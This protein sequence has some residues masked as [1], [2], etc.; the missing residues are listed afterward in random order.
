MAVSSNIRDWGEGKKKAL[1][2]YHAKK[3]KEGS[4]EIIGTD[5]TEGRYNAYLRFS[6]DGKEISFTN[7]SSHGI[8]E[9]LKKKRIKYKLDTRFGWH[10]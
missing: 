6:G 3:T 4:L 5:V 10:K 1:P 8:I 7:F 9:I 2:S